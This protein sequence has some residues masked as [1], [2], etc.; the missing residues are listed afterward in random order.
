MSLVFQ[1]ID[2]PSP[3]RVFTPPPVGGGGGHTRWAE[4]GWG[5]N[6]LE[7]ERHRIASVCQC[8]SP[9]RNW[10]SPI[11][12]PPPPNQGGHTRLRVGGWG[13]PNS[14]DWRKAS[15]SATLW[16]RPT[17][18][19]KNSRVLYRIEMLR[20]ESLSIVLIVKPKDI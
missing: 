17:K 14:D 12:S 15:H 5:V 20:K 7:D 13:S 10:D 8:M 6:I 16:A 18:A 11:S 1:N 3:R 19:E 9:R 2:P 4:R